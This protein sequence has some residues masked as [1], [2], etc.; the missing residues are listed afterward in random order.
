MAGGSWGPASAK[1]EVGRRRDGGRRGR[2]ISCSHEGGKKKGEGLRRWRKVRTTTD[3][4]RLFLCHNKGHVIFQ[5]AGQR[6]LSRRFGVSRRAPLTITRGRLAT[7]PRSRFLPPLF[8]FL[9]T[10]SPLLGCYPEHSNLIRPFDKHLTQ[11]SGL[12][13]RLP[14]AQGKRLRLTN[15]HPQ[16]SLFYLHLSN[17]MPVS[18]TQRWGK[19]KPLSS[20]AE[21]ADVQTGVA[22][23]AGISAECR[24]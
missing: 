2:F 14:T 23:S 5:P 1:E 13:S 9:F 22:G 21:R 8:F 12:L 11:S 17:S 15:F 3:L 10:P 6:F 16:F 24:R 20:L 4:G 7:I 19:S 18:V